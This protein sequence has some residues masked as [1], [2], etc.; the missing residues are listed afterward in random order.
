VRPA[1]NVPIR[2]IVRRFWPDL[3]RFR[4]RLALTA[5]FVVLV[6]VV[7]AAQIWMFK[8]AI[9]D[10]LVP[11]DLRPMV[12]IAP[13]YVALSAVGGVVSF[14]GDYLTT[15][16]G[17]H[18]LLALR[19]R[20]FRHVQ[21]LSLDFFERNRLG[22]VVAR[23]TGDVQ[24][25]ET[26]VLSGVARALSYGLEILIFAVALF[27]LRWELALIALLIAPVAATATRYFSRPVKPASPE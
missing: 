11:R 26:F 6:P 10:V 25:I 14:G 9:D 5:I 13:L 2:D 16:L 23:L 15:W 4:R 7:D 21:G 17:E 18:F 22:D 12:W 20:L 8:L 1:G 19:A 24:A 3:R 27:Y